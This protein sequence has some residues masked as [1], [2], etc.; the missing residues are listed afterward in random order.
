MEFYFDDDTVKTCTYYSNK[1]TFVDTTNIKDS[2]YERVPCCYWTSPT[3]I[4]VDSLCGMETD[5]T[6]N[7]ANYGA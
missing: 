6:M 3:L 4:E 2:I 1:C 7:G 5:I